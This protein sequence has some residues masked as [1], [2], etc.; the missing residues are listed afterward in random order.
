[1]DIRGGLLERGHQ[2]SV[3]RRKWRF[4]LLSL[5]I[6]Q[7][8]TFMATIIILYYVTPEWLFIDAETDDLE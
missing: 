4:S 5:A 1:M 3:G 2:M 7:T 6:I 8:F